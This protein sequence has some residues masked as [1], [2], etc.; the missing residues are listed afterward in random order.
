MISR[1]CCSSSASMRALWLTTT[2]FEFLIDFNDLELHGLAHEDVVVA[3]GTDVD[4]RAG[5]ECL[6]AE[7]VDDHAA[8]RAA[9]DVALDDFVLLQSLVDAVPRTGCASLAVGEDKLALLVLLVLDEDFHLVAHFDVGVVAEFVERDDAV[10]L[11][12]DV[13]HGLTLVE[14]DDGAFDHFFVLYGVEA[15]VVGLR[16]LLARLAGMGVA[17][18]KCVPVEVF[19]CCFDFFFSHLG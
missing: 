12:T 4:L 2:F 9:L 6:D 17:I 5:Q 16:E 10:A 8:F 7:H 13:H 11:V 15:L 18:L 19:N 3:D 1:F 14:G